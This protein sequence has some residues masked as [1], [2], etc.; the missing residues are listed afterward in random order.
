MTTKFLIEVPHEA[1]TVSCLRAVET[2][3]KSGSH[4]ITRADW[5][6]LD[7][8]HKAWIIVD[9]ENKEQARAIVPP[10]FRAEA[11]IVQLNSFSLEQVEDLMRQHKV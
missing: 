11:K 7:G 1:T 3:L 6:C 8:E 2:F 10:A 9:V 5:G 4:F